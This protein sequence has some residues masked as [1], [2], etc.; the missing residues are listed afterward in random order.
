VLEAVEDEV[1]DRVAAA[2]IRGSDPVEW[3]ELGFG[4]FPSEG[5]KPDITQMMLSD[6]PS[7]LGRE[8]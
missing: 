3:L 4:T 6:G 1:A 7:V 5:V 2:A 8:P